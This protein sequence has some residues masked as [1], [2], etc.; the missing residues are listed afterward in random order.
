[1]E[2]Q[3]T[4][5][6]IQVSLECK[7]DISADNQRKGTHTYGPN[8]NN[9]RNDSVQERGMKG[10]DD[11]N[12]SDLAARQRYLTTICERRQDLAQQIKENWISGRSK[13]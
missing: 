5:D 3:L 8:D 12:F 6:K 7:I 11:S 10:T 1:M 4:Y 13:Q 2:L 9:Y